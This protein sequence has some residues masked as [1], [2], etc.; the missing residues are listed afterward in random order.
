MGYYD[1]H[2]DSK[3]IN[4][5]VNNDE[6]RRIAGYEQEIAT[7]LTLGSQYYLEHMVDHKNYLRTLPNGFPI[8]DKNRHLLTTR[9]TFLTH[10]QNMTWSL[11][12]FFSPSDMDFYLRP[13]INYKINDQWITELGGNIFGGKKDYTFFNQSQNNSNIYLSIRFGF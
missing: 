13:K 9:L 8:R 1:A 4:P 7:N 5:F 10:N 12:S 6:F 11:F 3:G 2:E